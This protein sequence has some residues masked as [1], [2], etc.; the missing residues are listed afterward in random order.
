MIRDD[1]NIAIKET[2]QA[3]AKA[4][5]QLTSRNQRPSKELCSDP[6]QTHLLSEVQRLNASINR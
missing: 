4:Q 1:L 3:L 2:G 6:A 5:A